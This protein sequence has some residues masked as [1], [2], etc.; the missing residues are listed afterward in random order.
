MAMTRDEKFWEGMRWAGFGATFLFMAFPIF[1]MIL[2]SFKVA[3][4]AYSTK[5]FF[6]PTLNNFISIF[7]D[8]YN[9]GPL[10][11][12]SV[13]VSFSTVAV[14]IPA[15]TC[16]AYAFSR[17]QFKG[18]NA[19]MVSVLSSQFVPPVV[20]VLP[21]FILFKNLHLLDTRLALVILNLS[22]VLPFAVWMIK[23][24][25]DALPPDIESAAVVDGCNRFQVLRHITLPLIMPGVVTSAVFGFIQSW[26][27]FLFALILTNQKAVTLT[28][29][30]MGLHT[31]KGI[32]WEH[33]AA[34]SML[35]MIP[36]FAISF[37]IREYFISGLT[38][39]A[40]K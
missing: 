16:A 25:I 21:F 6:S 40:V 27:E 31:D 14:A 32:L 4:D 8:P 3:R 28:V 18:K 33:M 17:Y 22:F 19:L 34:A 5:V 1:W 26:N 11:F 35:I 24:F 10:L 37:T 29:G 39:G 30:L 23:G 2:T 15:A 9:F 13:V 7:Q 38:M 12:N 36:I 20:V